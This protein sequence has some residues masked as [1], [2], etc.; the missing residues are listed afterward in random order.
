MPDR[1]DDIAPTWDALIRSFSCPA[2]FRDAK[3]GVW[4]HWGPQAVPGL[5]DWYARYMYD[6]TKPHYRHHV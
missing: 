5:G 2:W 1:P 3:F 4:S 6:E